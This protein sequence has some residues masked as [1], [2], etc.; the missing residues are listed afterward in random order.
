MQRIVRE[1]VESLVKATSEYFPKDDLNCWGALTVPGMK[2]ALESKSWETVD[3]QIERLGEI[4]GNPNC[5]RRVL[6]TE[7]QQHNPVNAAVE[8]WWGE[9]PDDEGDLGVFFP[10]TVAAW[11]AD[12]TAKVHYEDDCKC[13]RL[14]ISS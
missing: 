6:G 7:I 5:E 8:V 2:Q 13:Q 11:N 12:G 1:Y 9:E 14:C 10:A 3:A 4:F